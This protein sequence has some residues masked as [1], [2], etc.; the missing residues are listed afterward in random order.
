MGQ[1]NKRQPKSDC[2]G[3]V[4]AKIS[5]VVIPILIVGHDK[6][7]KTSL[8][9]RFVFGDNLEESNADPCDEIENLVSKILS[10]TNVLL[11]R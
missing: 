6:V 9:R 5:T 4:L 7:G 3:N 1:E 2:V 10:G 11:V 8:I